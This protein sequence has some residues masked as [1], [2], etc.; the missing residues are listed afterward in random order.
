V[1]VLPPIDTSPNVIH[2]FGPPAAVDG[3]PAKAP[4]KGF[5]YPHHPIL[6]EE[7]RAVTCAR[8]TAP[9]DPFD[10]L[11]LVA[12]RHEEWKRVH[13]ETATMRKQLAALQDEEK[14]VKARTKSHSR[15]DAAVAVEEE[16]ERE[17]LRRQQTADAA[18]EITR[19][20]ER[21]LRLARTEKAA[22]FD[23]KKYWRQRAL[24][25]ERHVRELRAGKEG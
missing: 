23:E 5:C 2:L 13:E 3:A 14:R 20:S 4:R 16:R 21:I 15:K 9:L 12:R 10:V 6:D 11:L 24:S 17:G 18:K 8:C 22:E 7:L 25:A 1:S 19:L